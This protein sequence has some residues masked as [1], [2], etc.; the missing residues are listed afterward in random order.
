VETRL[1]VVAGARLDWVPQETIVFNRSGLARRLEADVDPSA[2]L[3]AVES[4]VLGRT[5]MGESVDQ[6]VVRDAWRIRRGGRLVFADTTRI[7]GDAKGLMAGP[8]TGGGAA[9]FATLVLV[10]PDAEA[11]LET[12]RS[13]LADMTFEG[14]ASAWNGILVARMLAAGGQP[15]RS[16]L[17]R[18]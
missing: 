10:A 7:D 3:L 13:V 2:T 5:A 11:R 12:A 9:A 16:G 15:L 1:T 18:L 14:G 4:V 6:T 8:S 17:I